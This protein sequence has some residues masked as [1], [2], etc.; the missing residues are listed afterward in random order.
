[1]ALEMF[2]GKTGDRLIARLPVKKDSYADVGITTQDSAPA[3]VQLRYE[4]GKINGYPALTPTLESLLAINHAVA[5]SI[6]N[7]RHGFDKRTDTL[8][9]QIGNIQRAKQRTNDTLATLGLSLAEWQLEDAIAYLE[10]LGTK[11]PICPRVMLG[12]TLQLRLPVMYGKLSALDLGT[13]A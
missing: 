2:S 1:M 12:Q 6:V 13:V 10:K 7:Q 5:S 9:Q 11:P 3:V 4:G 8:E